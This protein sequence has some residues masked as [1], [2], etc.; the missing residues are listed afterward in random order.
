MDNDNKTITVADMDESVSA[1]DMR[2][3]MSEVSNNDAAAI[4]TDINTQGEESQSVENHISMPKAETNPHQ[5]ASLSQPEQPNQ[6]AS[7]AI[8]KPSTAWYKPKG[9]ENTEKTQPSTPVMGASSPID[10]NITMPD[11]ANG[12]KE[13]KERKEAAKGQEKLSY[14]DPVL[15]AFRDAKGKIT[16]GQPQDTNK[17]GT[18]GRPTLMNDDTLNKLRTAFLMGC[19]DR[20][21]CLFAEISTQTLYNYQEAHPEYIEQKEDWKENPLLK[22]RST[23]YLNLND[24]KIAAWY[25]ERKNKKEFAQVQKHIGSD[26]EEDAPIKLE[27]VVP[28]IPAKSTTED[29]TS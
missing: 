8:N 22:A 10:D 20:E 12:E 26:D 7:N 28:A 21:A 9:S 2:S 16:K 19:S 29:T 3:L 18:A 1:D 17:N 24:P 11:E 27:Y 4:G 25:L 23:V 13:L 5:T 6:T 15:A 14:K